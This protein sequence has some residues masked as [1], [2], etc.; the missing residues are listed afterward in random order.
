VHKFKLDISTNPT[1][2]MTVTNTTMSL[3]PNH[4]RKTIDFGH[5]ST[6]QSLS[7]RGGIV[8]L[9][10]PHPTHGQVLVVPWAQFPKDKFYD[11]PFV[12]R[13]RAKPLDWFNK[14]T[15]F[16]LDFGGEDEL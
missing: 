6:V 1:I 9:S 7:H 8:S 12:R 15:D 2:N 10:T 14:A 3:L 16:G 13:Y 5:R 11:Q 4:P